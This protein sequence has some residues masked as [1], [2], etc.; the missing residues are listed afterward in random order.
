MK[1]AKWVRRIATLRR[2]RGVTSIEY[3]LIS[4]LIAVVIAVAVTQVG[5]S[6]VTLFDTVAAEVTCAA[7][8]VGC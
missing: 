7:S 4:A 3:A 1:K 5:T 6:L 2:Q 8:G